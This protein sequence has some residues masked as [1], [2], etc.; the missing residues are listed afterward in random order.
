MDTPYFTGYIAKN[1]ETS[2]FHSFIFL[3]RTSMASTLNAKTIHRDGKAEVKLGLDENAKILEGEGDELIIKNIDGSDAK[4]AK[5]NIIGM[6]TNVSDDNKLVTQA[7]LKAMMA[8]IK[9]IIDS[10]NE[11][12]KIVGG[13]NDGSDNL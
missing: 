10:A 8:N 9:D 7:D 4:I 1:M 11:L 2:G 5:E 12:A 3:W 13:L 6:P